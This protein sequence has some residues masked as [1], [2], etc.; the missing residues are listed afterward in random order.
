MQSKTVSYVSTVRERKEE[1]SEMVGYRPAF[2][3][4]PMSL[5][6]LKE[7][8]RSDKQA[9]TIRDAIKDASSNLI[10]ET[11]RVLLNKKD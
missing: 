11:P 10:D 5:P 3:V 1:S 6:A 2:A 9:M 4:E 8:P 7:T